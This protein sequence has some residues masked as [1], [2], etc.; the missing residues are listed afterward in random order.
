MIVVEFIVPV[1]HTTILGVHEGGGEIQSQKA[2]VGDEVRLM[3]VQLPEQMFLV[4]GP[5]RTGAGLI[6]TDSE[7][8]GPGL[9]Q[10]VLVP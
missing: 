8:V 9:V 2:P 4:K 6:V 10:L 5:L 1:G 7:L 3:L